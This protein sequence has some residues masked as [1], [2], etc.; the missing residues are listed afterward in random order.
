MLTKKTVNQ[1]YR[2]NNVKVLPPL[3]ANNK[4]LAKYGIL[5]KLAKVKG[6]NTK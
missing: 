6:L 1:Y 2:G 5:Q 3:V 4:Y